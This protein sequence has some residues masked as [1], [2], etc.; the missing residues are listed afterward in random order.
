MS[1]RQNAS[2]LENYDVK[3]LCTAL[4]AAAVVASSCQND[5]AGSPDRLVCRGLFPPISME[6]DPER[7]RFWC[8]CPSGRHDATLCRD[9]HL[10][11]RRSF[12][13]RIW[14]PKRGET[15]MPFRVGVHI[16][17]VTEN[18]YVRSTLPD[19]TKSVK[20]VGAHGTVAVTGASDEGLCRCAEDALAGERPGGSSMPDY[21]VSS[22]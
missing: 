16:A 22:A 19:G 20:M 5:P 21:P 8:R 15:A 11:L 9:P 18:L 13:R 3:K 10:L 14:R 17:R 2:H 7:D 4:M 1:R 6:N 12:R